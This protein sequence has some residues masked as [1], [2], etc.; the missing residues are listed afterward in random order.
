M[1]DDTASNFASLAGLAIGTIGTVIVAKTAADLIRD[2]TREIT[3]K[4]KKRKQAKDD[5]YSYL[6]R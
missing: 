2:Q 5:L 3:R 4:G 1:S 6:L